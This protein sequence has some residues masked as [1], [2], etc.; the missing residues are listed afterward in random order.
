MK[1][2]LKQNKERKDKTIPPDIVLLRDADFLY[3]KTDDIDF[4]PLNYRKY[5]SEEALQNFA[6]ELKQ[7]GIISPLTVRQSGKGRYELVAG[8][9]RLRA[10]RIAA[11]PT[12]PA[13]IVTLTDEQV[14][15]IQLAE[16]LQRENPHPMHEAQAIGQMQKNGKSIDE[17]A[18]RLGKSKSFLY[19]RIRLLSLIE[20]F[21]EMVLADVI[22]LQDAF[23]IASLSEISQTEFFAEHCSKWK[24]Q[25][26]FGFRNLDYYLNH[27]RYDLKRAPFNTKDKKLVPEVGA[28]TNCPSNSA[29]LKS[30]FPEMSKEAICSNKECYN[31]KCQVHFI[32]ALKA[33]IDTYQPIGLIYSNNFAEFAESIIVTIPNAEA[34]SR[35]D[36]NDVSVIEKPVTPDKEDYTYDNDEGETELD[37]DEFNQAMDDYYSELETYNLNVQSGHYNIGVLLDDK[38]CEPVYFSTEKPRQYQTG[39]TEVT[40]KQV[41]E[42]IKSG[43]A[44]PELLN[45]EITRLNHREKRQEELDKEKV[46]LTIH[47]EFSE[48]AARPENNAAFTQA[49]MAG[50]R[51]IIYQSLDYH[52]RQKVNETLFQQKGK[53][54]TSDDSLKQIFEQFSNMTEQQFSY[55]LRMAICSKSESKYP[56][57]QS[58][59]FLYQ[60]AKEAGFN[61]QAI[62]NAQAE[63]RKERKEKLSKRI[64]ELEKKIKKLE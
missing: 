7:H 43:D 46:Q 21:Q 48:F 26:Q 19:S 23:Q 55:L 35:H 57:Q 4:S 30:L 53:D 50:A 13:A 41:Q 24:K 31:K 15:E 8:E 20:N 49:D 12:V 29:S 14:I 40:A 58:G 22:S 3:I 9:R 52:A 37:S 51:L 34:L 17:I 44:T 1:T 39:K 45:Q 36:Y 54:E 60:I 61:T 6:L 38:S 11:L 59:Y 64:K 62:E 28:C 63:K 56:A 5:F 42:A 25:K 10:A 47:N 2:K 16:N 27:Y 33:A 18:A 32:C